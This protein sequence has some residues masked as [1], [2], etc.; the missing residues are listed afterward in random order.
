MN[1]IAN[2]CLIIDVPDFFFRG[3]QTDPLEFR[4][5]FSGRGTML[6]FAVSHAKNW[7]RLATLKTMWNMKFLPTLV[8][9]LCLEVWP[10]N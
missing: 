3:G 10:G 4:N 1:G 6:S 5:F 7:E 9:S 2:Y 8:I